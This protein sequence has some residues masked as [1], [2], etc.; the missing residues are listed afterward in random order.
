[1]NI[2]CEST[3]LYLRHFN[4]DETDIGHILLLNSQPK[5]LEY[6]H[7]PVLQTMEDASSILKDHI[8]P[9][10]SKNLGRWSVHLK[11]NDAFIGWCGLKQ[12]PERNNEIDLGYRYLPE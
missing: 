11:E 5:V 12:R 7:E 8:L 10:Y 3:R 4:F 1:M 6:L 2:I 9:Q